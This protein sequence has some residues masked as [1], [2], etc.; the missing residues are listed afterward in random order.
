MGA[1][2][3]KGLVDREPVNLRERAY[4]SFTRHLLARDIRAGQF[5][6]QRELVEL[7]GLPLGAVRELIPR[8]EAE[9]LIKTAPQRGMQV[10]PIDLTLVRD[11]FQFRLFLEQGA[12]A[13]FAAEAT[14]AAIAQLRRAHLAVIEACEE[15][16]AYV[17]ISAELVAEAQSVDWD[18]H[19]TIINSLSNA[20]ISNSYRVNA[21][22]IRLIKHEQTVLN[23]ALVVPTMREHLDIIDA[24]ATRDPGKASAALGAH[25]VNA[26]NRAM[27]L[28]A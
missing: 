21:I 2:V 18:L 15:D 27:S 23:G 14:D 9:G 20:I 10:A 4:D 26:R 5:I 24:I 16:A 7:T 6:S 3:A 13:V 28:R 11:A 19:S 8:L 1:I 25:I 22:K 12:V 17:D